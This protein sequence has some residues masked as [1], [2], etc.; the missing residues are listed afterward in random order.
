[1]ISEISQISYMKYLSKVLFFYFSLYCRR[2][3]SEQHP[4]I[5]HDKGRNDVHGRV[6]LTAGLFLIGFNS[7]VDWFGIYSQRVRNNESRFTL[8]ISVITMD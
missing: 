6:L 3:F 8:K 1:M 2:T 5:F 7:V 4:Y